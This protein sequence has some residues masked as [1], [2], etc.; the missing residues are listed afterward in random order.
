[1]TR[2]NMAVVTLS[3]GTQ[4]PFSCVGRIAQTLEHLIKAGPAGI[5]ALEMA[6]WAV[7]LS[8]YVWVLR[9]KHGLAIHTTFEEHRGDYPGKHARYTLLSQVRLSNA[10]QEQ[11]AA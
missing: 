4:Q 1:M 3:D 10:E 2:L 5:T 8:H 9:H 11:D 6:S 7:R